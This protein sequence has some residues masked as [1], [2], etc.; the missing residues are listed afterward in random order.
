MTSYESD[1]INRKRKGGH[2]QKNGAKRA[3]G[4]SLIKLEQW[5]VNNVKETVENISNIQCLEKLGNDIKSEALACTTEILGFEDT[6]RSRH[7]KLS[8][9]PNKTPTLHEYRTSKFLSGENFFMDDARPLS[10]ETVCNIDP[11]KSLPFFHAPL[12]QSQSSKILPKERALS[13]PVTIKTRTRG[14]FTHEQRHIMEAI[15]RKGTYKNPEV[16]ELC[17]LIT[18][19]E[20][21]Q[22]KR[23][24]NDRKRRKK[25]DEDV[26]PPLPVSNRT[27][28]G[29]KRRNFTSFQRE[30]LHIAHRANALEQHKAKEIMSDV[31]GLTVKQVKR[32]VLDQR[33]KKR[34][35]TSM[36]KTKSRNEINA[37]NVDIVSS[38]AAPQSTPP[39]RR[40][41][42]A[43]DHRKHPAPP[44]SST[45]DG[46]DTSFVC[47][48]CALDRQ[49]LDV[50]VCV[51]CHKKFHHVCLNNIWQDQFPVPGKAWTCPYCNSPSQTLPL[52]TFV[53]N[54][55]GEYYYKGQAV[56]AEDKN[57]GSSTAGT[58]FM[59]GRES[60]LLHFNN[61]SNIYN[62][63]IP[64]K[65][66][67]VRLCRQQKKPVNRKQRNMVE[68]ERPA[69]FDHK[70]K[71]EL[72]KEF[73]NT[74]ILM[75]DSFL[76]FIGAITGK[77]DKQLRKWRSDYKY[78]VQK[79]GQAIPVFNPS[80]P[81][82]DCGKNAT[83]FLGK[84]WQHG[85]L[86]IRNRGYEHAVSALT[87]L[88]VPKIR[89]WISDK[90]YREK[91]KSKAHNNVSLNVASY[92]TEL[93]VKNASINTVLTTLL[94]YQ[95]LILRTAMSQ[96][97]LNFSNPQTHKAMAIYCG[98]NEGD[99][100][101]FL[102]RG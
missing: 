3:R 44:S 67:K 73:C 77:T 21:K 23:W 32:W 27:A 53:L 14:T 35:N 68:I 85:I 25:K 12:A 18:S 47:C 89:K 80:K 62:Q 43:V 78:R 13:S 94:P 46:L 66:T 52:P 60:I 24:F 72:M 96:G 76:P 84:L 64:S 34:G 90:R 39:P 93:S 75:E 63:W 42:S 10:L 51:N 5:T 50:F 33:R 56:E 87:G 1:I 28:L 6:N 83:K 36:K 101:N 88:S 58:I 86:R 49:E 48:G 70:T 4:E 31:L 79:K 92:A 57:T 91:C 74:G 97:K 71:R 26:S 20:T 55:R 99:V 19:L 54:G 9:L 61:W 17:R 41:L 59:V 30:M 7:C 37:R 81:G 45:M 38:P 65:S 102:N 82:R 15:W 11:N 22:I 69:D 29:G 98:I 40:V 100:L 8:P 2:L 95:E 16:V